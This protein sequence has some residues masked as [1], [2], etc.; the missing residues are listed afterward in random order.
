MGLII[1]FFLLY[2]VLCVTPIVQNYGH[3]RPWKSDMTWRRTTIDGKSQHEFF[4][5]H[6]FFFLKKALKIFRILKNALTSKCQ[7]KN[8]ISNPKKIK[9]IKIFPFSFYLS[10]ARTASL[11]ATLRTLFDCGVSFPSWDFGRPI[12]N[13]STSC[14][15]SQN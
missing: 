6:K 4:F 10:A 3:G 1:F 11:L 5:K 8:Q 12:I 7:C 15:I 14:N 9:K 2:H 13:S